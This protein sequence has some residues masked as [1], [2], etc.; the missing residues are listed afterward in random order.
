MP[1][2][3]AVITFVLYHLSRHTPQCLHAMSSEKEC[4]RDE[5]RHKLDRPVILLARN[6]VSDSCA[7]R[8][9]KKLHEELCYFVTLS[10]S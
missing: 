5:L 8:I 3:S 7:L 2:S 6:D 4:K 1:S 9:R 10:V